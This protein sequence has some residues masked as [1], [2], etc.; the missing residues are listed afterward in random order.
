MMIFLKSTLAGVAALI[1]AVLM[2]YGLAI[3]VPRI[4]STGPLLISLGPFEMWEVGV[5]AL[6]IFSAGFCWTIRRTLRH[7]RKV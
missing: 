2:I 6:L 3:G 7:H 4:V 1:L 5:V